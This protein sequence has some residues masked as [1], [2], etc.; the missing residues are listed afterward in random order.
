MMKRCLLFVPVFAA[1]LTVPSGAR[2]DVLP[3]LEVSRVAGIEAVDLDVDRAAVLLDSAFTSVDRVTYEVAP[4]DTLGAIAEEYGV[5]VAD[6]RR[7]NGIR[8]DRINIGQELTIHTRGG[9][10]DR[11]RETYEVRSGDTGTAIARRQGVTL[12]ELQRWNRG[13]NLDRLRIGQELTIYVS[14]GEAGAT[15]TPQRGRLR[16]GQQ[17]EDGTGYVVRN[18]ERSFG[19]PGT[20]S[21]IRNG[22]ARVTARYV[23]VPSLVVHDVSY[24]HGGRMEP[25]ASHQNGLDVDISYYRNNCEENACEW[26]TVE[27]DEI[28]ARLQWYLFKSWIDQGLVEY[29]FVD[30]DLQ[31]PLYE[32]ARARGASE[33]QLSEWFQYP[34]RGSSGII[35][36]ES[37]HAD[38][39]HV[40]FN[41]IEE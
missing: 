17:L 24:E 21:A 13:T 10:G 34:D 18:P 7:W 36:H 11:V 5:T 25:H 32:Y 38:H 6:L 3:T 4:G 12:D 19:V 23:N 22:I 26:Q 30:F 16:G 15:G 37:G 40:R 2:A 27:A 41:V 29:I 28:D 35:R 31:A 39:F 8:G 20:I 33:E 1:W 9:G 14:G